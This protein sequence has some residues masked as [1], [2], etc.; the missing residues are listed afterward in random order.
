MESSSLVKA[1]ALLEATAAGPNGRSLAELAAEAGLPKPTAHRILKT[2][3]ELGYLEKS[4]AGVYRQ[5]PRMKRLVSDDPT[6]R[7][8]AA[9]EPLLASLHERTLETV[10][11]GI[12]RHDRVVY[13][14]VLESPQ[15]LRRVATLESVDPFH[16]TA[17][18]RAIVAHLPASRQQALL[19]GARLE[20]TT[21]RTQTSRRALQQ[22]LAAAARDGYA[23]EVDETDLGVTCVGAPIL[24]AG[25]AVAAV[26]LS[27]PTARASDDVLPSLIA[28]VR[29]TARSISDA[30][31]DDRAP[32]PGLALH[33]ATPCP[34]PCR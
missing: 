26:S 13:L 18:G 30:L 2:L 21:P 27:M 10:N 9:A 28:E 16:S 4:S 19:E 6:R 34:Q 25:E 32:P 11:L 24:A 12:L 15:P 20:P 23:V 22:V 3:A 17:L 7:L 31:D 14:R 1:L 33:D 8:L 5:T 29:S